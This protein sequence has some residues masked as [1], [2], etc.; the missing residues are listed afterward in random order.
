MM[1]DGVYSLSSLQAAGGVDAAGV[2]DI[3]KDTAVILGQVSAPEVN[4]LSLMT[5]ASC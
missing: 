2:G 4:N 3:A 5:S 1:I